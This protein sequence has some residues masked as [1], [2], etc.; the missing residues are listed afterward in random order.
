[1]EGVFVMRDVRGDRSTPRMQEA[2]SII[3]AFNHT[4]LPPPACDGPLPS[5]PSIFAV[6]TVAYIIVLTLN[7]VLA[8]CDVSTSRERGMGDG[9]GG[10]HTA[11][12]EIHFDDSCHP[13]PPRPIHARLIPL[14]C[15]VFPGPP[16]IVTVAISTSFSSPVALY[17]ECMAIPGELS[18]C[19]VLLFILV[20]K[21]SAIRA[22]ISE[23][24]APRQATSCLAWDL[25][26]GDGDVF[27]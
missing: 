22:Q 14:T 4:R 6:I 2:T 27:E 9:F 24:E 26:V 11:G 20:S 16:P 3:F 12:G 1:M 10:K 15:D 5:P 7:A 21:L 23:V 17:F 19:R 8:H 13:A 25:D 18:R